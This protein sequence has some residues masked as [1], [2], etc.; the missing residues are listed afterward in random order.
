[1]FKRSCIF[2]HIFVKMEISTVARNRKAF[3][4]FH[5][6]DNYEAGISLYGSEVKSIREGN[7]SLKESYVVIRR[8][9]AWLRGVHIAAYSNTGYTGHELVRDR[10]LLLHRNEIRKINSK[11]AEKGLTAVPTKLYFKNGKIKVEIGLAK[12]KKLHDKRDTKKRR[13]VERD[14]KRALSYKP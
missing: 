8:G 13:D 5:I 1:M 12:G 4:Q 3:H 6:I 14:I 11:L 9:E 10:K 7:V 2:D